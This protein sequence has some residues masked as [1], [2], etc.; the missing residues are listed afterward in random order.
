MSVI[1]SG[2]TEQGA[3]VPVQVDDSGKVVSTA[4]ATG[5]YVL[6][7]GDTMTGPLV[8]PEG[9]KEPLEAATKYYVD[10]MFNGAGSVFAAA[11][12]KSST[13]EGKS[14]NIAGGRRRDV[15][16]YEFYFD[17]VPFDTNY[18]VYC[19][20][21]TAQVTLHQSQ[22]DQFTFTL[23][24]KSTTTGGAVDCDGSLWVYI[25][26]ELTEFAMSE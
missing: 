25:V 17:R 18:I 7:T 19:Q 24:S 5:D 9:P 15:G 13:M 12:F 14:F 3:I 2:I 20:S 16:V 8:L 23:A 21:D 22:L 11:T 6:K 4:A 10:S 1:W 26:K